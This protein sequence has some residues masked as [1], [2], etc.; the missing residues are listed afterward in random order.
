MYYLF[1]EK[2]SVRCDVVHTDKQEIS[3]KKIYDEVTENIFYIM[4]NV[5]IFKEIGKKKKMGDVYTL[6]CVRS[7]VLINV[8]GLRHLCYSKIYVVMLLGYKIAGIS[9]KLE[10]E[11]K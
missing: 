6:L 8:F 2:R 3:L 11:Q 4:N 7:A 9:Q 5:R 10:S 1:R